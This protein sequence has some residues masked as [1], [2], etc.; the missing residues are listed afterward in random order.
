MGKNWL[1]NSQ[2]YY[3]PDLIRSGVQGNAQLRVCV[4]EAGHLSGPPVVEQ[5]SGNA[6]L[7]QGALNVVR[8]GRYARAVRGDTPVPN[9]YE[10]R[11]V[12]S[13]K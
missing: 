4:D 9:C 7:D 1:P 3:P 5:T 10:F 2:D 8:A 12:F 13:L 11:I 6:R